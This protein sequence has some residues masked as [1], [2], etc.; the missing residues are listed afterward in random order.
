MPALIGDSQLTSVLL[1]CSSPAFL[2]KMS[3]HVAKNFLDLPK[4]KI[5]LILGIWGKRFTPLCLPG[6]VLELH[7]PCLRND[8]CTEVEQ[9]IS[10]FVCVCLQGSSKAGLPSTIC[11]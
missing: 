2:D 1:L 4:I 6:F 5:P 8:F 9:H 10:F 11:L 3:I 7:I